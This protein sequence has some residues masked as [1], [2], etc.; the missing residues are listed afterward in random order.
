[1]GTSVTA[2]DQYF[3][4]L[5]CMMTLVICLFA[6]PLSRRLR[7]VDYP[8]GG[9][10][11]HATPTPLIGGVAIMVP[12]A[13][14]CATILL[15]EP[16]VATRL[17]LTILLCGLGVAV[18]GFMDDQAPVSPRSRF[19]LLIIFAVMAFILDP[20]LVNDGL[21]W[22]GDFIIV[23]A[24]AFC[25]LIVVGQVGLVSAINM[26]D[27]M[28]GLVL[29]LYLVWFAALAF[30]SE[31]VVQAA[32]LLVCAMLIVTLLFNARGRLFLGDCGTFAVTFVLG[33]LVIAAHNSGW[34]SF[35]Q[36]LLWFFIPIVDCLRLI[37]A[38][39]VRGRSPFL[40]DKNHFHHRLMHRFGQT[41]AFALYT[42][43]V[44]AG[45]IAVTVLP[46]FNYI[47][48]AMLLVFYI[49]FVV[50]RP[51]RVGVGEEPKRGRNVVKLRDRS[52]RPPPPQDRQSER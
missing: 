25:V 2:L 37:W 1:M 30:I 27:G 31:G 46:E 44:T 10:K 42:V 45:V 49:G 29:T 38:R 23:P 40:G 6:E 16:E 50:P 20:S 41:T 32:S 19:L 48:C 12:L 26:A 52:E 24:W 9:R 33:L 15:V 13:L 8:D 21:R 47:I 4:L 36:M 18:M 34:L 17:H 11:G 51:A 7:V 39:L 43:M 3:P 22:D 35:D 5:F 14:W 28:N